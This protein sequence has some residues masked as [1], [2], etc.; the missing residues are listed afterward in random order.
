M[1]NPN[2]NSCAMNSDMALVLA[3]PHFVYN[4]ISGAHSIFVVQAIAVLGLEVDCILLY[5]FKKYFQS[6]SS[7]SVCDASLE[8]RCLMNIVKNSTSAATDSDTQAYNGMYEHMPDCLAL[9]LD[10]RSLKVPGLPPNA[11]SLVTSSRCNTCQKSN[12]SFVIDH[13][14]MQVDV[15]HENAAVQFLLDNE[16]KPHVSS[17]FECSYHSCTYKGNSSKGE[18]AAKEM[19]NMSSTDGRSPVK[20][21]TWR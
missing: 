8:L 19:P 18:K 20:S 10:C 21:L 13:P 3:I 7:N 4:F 12:K 5:I 2:S 6:L 9:V 11:F 15:L 16:M 14:Y 17:Q 1:A